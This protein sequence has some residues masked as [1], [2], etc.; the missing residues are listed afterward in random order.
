MP[1]ASEIAAEL[2]KVA[3]L[4]DAQPEHD[5]RKPTLS[6]YTFSKEDFLATL[7]GIPR[8]IAKRIAYET[9]YAE[10]VTD[11]LLVSAS[12]PQSMTCELVQRAQPAKY[13]CLPLLSKQEEES[14]TDGESTE[15]KVVMAAALGEG[16]DD[17]L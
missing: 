17:T 8:P 4:L 13:N 12:A 10:H 16:N 7:P 9:F 2:R 3:E 11:A 14:L 1:K 15:E 5:M 6:W